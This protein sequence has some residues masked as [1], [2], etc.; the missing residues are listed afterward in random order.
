[1]LTLRDLNRATL[2]RQHLLSRHEGDVADVV[3]RPAGLQAQEP[4]PPYLGLAAAARRFDGPATP[5]D[6]A[7]WSGLRGMREVMTGAVYLVDGFAAGTW[8]IK[9]SGKKARLL[10]SPFVAT[11]LGQVEE[12]EG[13]RL[14]AFAE[15]DAT[16]TA[17]EVTGAQ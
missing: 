5:A 4:R 2:T 7:T 15:P 14:L 10:I 17:L 13:L 11:D 1:M 3:H 8:Q 9:R 6:V 16:T 12:E